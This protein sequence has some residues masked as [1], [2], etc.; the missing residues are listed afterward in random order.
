[1]I[2]KSLSSSHSICDSWCTPCLISA[3]ANPVLKQQGSSVSLRPGWGV[4]AH[5]ETKISEWQL[6]TMERGARVGVLFYYYYYY[7]QCCSGPVVLNQLAG[8]Q[9]AKPPLQRG[10]DWDFRNS[11]MSNHQEKGQ[12]RDQA[13][14]GMKIRDI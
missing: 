3:P 10:H 7:L 13:V 1:M 11:V 6:E 14:W 4:C 9:D 5:L 2:F 12:E 8:S